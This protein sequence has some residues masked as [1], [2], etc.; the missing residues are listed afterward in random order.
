MRMQKSGEMFSDI[1]K[2]DG[3]LELSQM[4]H[5]GACP[6]IC[7]GFDAGVRLWRFSSGEFCLKLPRSPLR[8]GKWAVRLFA[9]RRP[10]G[11]FGRFCSRRNVA[12]SNNFSHED[13]GT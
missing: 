10:A 3:K 4:L 7:L 2:Y 12:A 9:A 11:P 13:G 6:T 8:F 1:R 5:V